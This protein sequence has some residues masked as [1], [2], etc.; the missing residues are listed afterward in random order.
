MSLSRHPVLDHQV[1]F[2]IEHFD[3][4]GFDQFLDCGAFQGVVLNLTPAGRSQE[5]SLAAWKRDLDRPAG[6]IDYGSDWRISCA[7]NAF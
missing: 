6:F 4:P 2:F 5:Q 1:V 3:L 7:V